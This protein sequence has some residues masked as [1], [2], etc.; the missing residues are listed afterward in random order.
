MF[1]SY[2][3]FLD[4]STLSCDLSIS[5]SNLIREM[6]VR[7]FVFGWVNPCMVFVLQAARY[8]C[9]PARIS[10]VAQDKPTSGKNKQLNPVITG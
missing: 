2:S 9:L 5:S 1:A 7:H 6:P 10:V 8:A 4:V 3:E